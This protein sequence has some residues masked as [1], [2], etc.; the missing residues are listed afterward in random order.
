LPPPYFLYSQK[1]DRMKN[2]LV[3]QKFENF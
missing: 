1:S 2:N 3:N